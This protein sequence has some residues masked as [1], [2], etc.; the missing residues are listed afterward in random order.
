MS[1][2]PKLKLEPLF[3]R[4]IIEPIGSES[5]TA[6]GIVIPDTA[7]KEKP[8]KGKIVA[9]GPGRMDDKGKNFPMHV[10]VGDMVLYGKYSGDEVKIDNIEYKI[11]HEDNIFAI[12]KE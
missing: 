4:V 3:D 9:V 11:L 2:K 1:N 8:Q 5:T 6:S 7:S 10:K 12:I